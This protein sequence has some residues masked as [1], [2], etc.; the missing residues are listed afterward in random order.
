MPIWRSE[1]LDDPALR[2]CALAAL[3]DQAVELAAQREQISD[4]MID[5]GE[6]PARKGVDRAARTIPIV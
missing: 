5:V 4:L 2:D 1:C 3:I 6:M